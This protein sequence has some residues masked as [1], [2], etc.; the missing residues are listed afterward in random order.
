MKYPIK[1]YLTDIYKAAI[2]GIVVGFIM[3]LGQIK[4]K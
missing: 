4:K 1:V 2:G 3:R